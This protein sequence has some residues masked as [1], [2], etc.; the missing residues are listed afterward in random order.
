M[1]EY[2]KVTDHG[3]SLEDY[4][5]LNEQCH[6]LRGIHDGHPERSKKDRQ[7]KA[8]L[9]DALMHQCIARDRVHAY[10]AL[11]AEKRKRGDDDE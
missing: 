11:H 5:E 7:G 2:V 6:F 1:R 4:E 8:I 3:P 10:L 9:K